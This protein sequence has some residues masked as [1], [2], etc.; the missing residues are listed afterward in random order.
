M[1]KES[2]TKRKAD[3]GWLARNGGVLA[4]IAFVAGWT[5]FVFVSGKGENYFGIEWNFQSTGQLAD[6]FGILGSGMAAIAAYFAFRTY[7]SARDES[8]SLERRA[9]EA[10][11]LNLL[12]RRFDVLARL[13]SV[14]IS[15]ADRKVQQNE[16]TGQ[17]V[18]DSLAGSLERIKRQKGDEFPASFLRVTS[19]VSGLANLLRFTYH[20]VAF[21]QR[22]F[23]ELNENE[24]MTKSDPAYQYLRLL[25]AQLSDSELAIIGLNC[26]YGEGHEKF[27]PLVERYALLHNINPRLRDEF[28]LD[29]LF[30][31]SAFGLLPED[32]VPAA[33]SPP[34][35]APTHEGSSNVDPVPD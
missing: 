26:A 18:L 15:F 7:Q 9:G 6:S 4:V 25:R 20:I 2:K 12:E 32:R 34:P 33:D 21:A 5:W 14:S 17:Q 1:S 28:Q 19:E 24:P 35:L 23:S 31:P 16:K 22:Q 30:E 27:K 8:A 29:P 11:F 10:S 3:A 13:R